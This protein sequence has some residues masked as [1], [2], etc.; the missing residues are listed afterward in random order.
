LHGGR[1]RHEKSDSLAGR[2]SFEVTHFRSTE[3]AATNQ[4]RAE[5]SAAL[6]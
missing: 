3:G 4:P 5:R 2:A 6:G 1:G